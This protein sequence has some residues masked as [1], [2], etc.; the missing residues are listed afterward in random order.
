MTLRLKSLTWN[1]RGI[2]DRRK[3]R[4]VT[5]YRKRHEIVVVFIQETHLTTQVAARLTIHCA[6]VTYFASYSND[7]LEGRH[8]D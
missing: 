7:A 5:A 4:L 1:V 3:L 2:N 8:L 6:A